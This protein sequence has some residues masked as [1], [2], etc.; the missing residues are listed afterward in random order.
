MAF[1]GTGNKINL[2]WAYAI[3]GPKQLIILSSPLSLPAVMLYLMWALVP[4]SSSVAEMSVRK[5]PGGCECSTTVRMMGS[6]CSNTG[7]WS[8]MSK[9]V[10]VT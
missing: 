5:E 7:L 2:S 1:Q 6:L 3:P 9:M 4:K 10:T 8:L